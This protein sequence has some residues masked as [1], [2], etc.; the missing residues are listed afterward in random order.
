[1]PAVC[2]VVRD[3]CRSAAAS[4]SFPDL[5]SSEFRDRESVSPDFRPGQ[6]FEV[7]L[8]EHQVLWLRDPFRPTLNDLRAPPAYF[9]IAHWAELEV[10]GVIESVEVSA[11]AARYVNLFAST[12]VEVLVFPFRY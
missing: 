9:P 2:S 10:A 1:M 5:V 6:R 4:N 3:L 11:V 12:L 8:C 7:P